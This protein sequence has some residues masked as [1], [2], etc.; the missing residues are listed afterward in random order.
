MQTFF[1]LNVEP[2]VETSPPLCEVMISQLIDS[3]LALYASSSG[4]MIVVWPPFSST[5]M[6]SPQKP[7]R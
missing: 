3:S 5:P 2:R 7:V 1:L 6:A 4:A